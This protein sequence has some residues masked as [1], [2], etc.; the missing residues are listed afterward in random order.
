MYIPVYFK[1][2]YTCLSVNYIYRNETRFLWSNL[3][4]NCSLF[5][6]LIGKRS[7]KISNNYPPKNLRYTCTTNF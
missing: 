2:I 5:L 7:T 4:V 6:L 1:L 3:K